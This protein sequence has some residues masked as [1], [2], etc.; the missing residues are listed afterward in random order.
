MGP[1]GF[2][3]SIGG[4]GESDQGGV[5][6]TSLGASG[7]GAASGQVGASGGTGGG[8]GCLR[9][10]D[11]DLRAWL[12]QAI[13]SEKDNE[14]HPAVVLTTTGLSVPLSELSLRYYFSGEAAGDWILTC[15]WVTKPGDSGH[16]YCDEGVHMR[17]LPV[18]PPQKQA[19]QY[20]EISFSDVTNAT[21][22]DGFPIEARFMF[23]R[24]GH[25]ML[26]L[27]NDYSFVPNLEPVL[28]EDARRFKQT[29]KV[30]VY[31]NGVLVWGQEPCP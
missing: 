15:L 20:L 30:T 5:G 16:G 14:I 19:D 8:A 7:Q 10:D 6:G 21:L 29:S 23:W 18:Q 28:D 9:S 22:S 12:Y 1:D 2:S 17:V 13:T 24:D 31:R 3:G 4:G 11:G 25:P 26:N 27:A